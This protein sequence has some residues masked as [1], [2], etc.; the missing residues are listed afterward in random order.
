MVRNTTVLQVIPALESGGAERTTVE[1]T[2]AI[3]CG[4]G[5]A[6]VATSGGRLCEEVRAAGG[7]VIIGPV[8]SKNPVTILRNAG[9]LASIIRHSAAAIVHARSR[10]PAW[11]AYLAAQRTGAAFVTTYHGAYRASSPLKRW[12]NS[13]MVRG[14][15]VIANSAYTAD[16]IRASY[17][18]APDRLRV[19]PRGA[20][21]SRFSPE[22]VSEQR[23]QFLA[24]EWRLPA[25]QSEKSS[26][27]LIV[28]LP[29]RMTPW[30]GHVTAIEAL[31]RLA[32]R[33][34]SADTGEA[35][36]SAGAG[37]DFRLILCGD[38]QGRGD[39]VAALSRIAWE[40]GVGDM[41][42]IVGHCADM[43][44]AYLLADII[45]QPSER[46]EAF[47][48]VAVEAGAMGRPVI[49]SDHGGARETVRHGETG[50]LTKPG[51]PLS[52][53]DA[54]AIIAGMSDEN[55]LAMGA[56][57]RSWVSGNFSIAAMTSATMAAYADALSISRAR[58][59]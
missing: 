21:L 49:A 45:L 19:I 31:G 2:S 3:V 54:L 12:Y 27:P 8:G 39:Y 15:V 16:A 38:L 48:R 6:L 37:R 30:K 44:A 29:A 11:S 58:R 5:R 23:L 55:R 53:A 41:V 25:M 17:G 33:N 40:A 43:P 51:D 13:S 18:L 52:L 42:T 1:I 56:E 24:Q 9:W 50:F 59:P 47:G 28:L 4:G 20:D 35:V 34:P 14:D 46:P 57:A 10:A 32:R 22:A 26:R 7:E 36:A